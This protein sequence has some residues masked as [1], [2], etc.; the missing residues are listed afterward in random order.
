MG[1]QERIAYAATMSFKLFLY[2]SMTRQEGDPVAKEPPGD[3]Y[4]V[5]TLVMS[6]ELWQRLTLL[7]EKHD[8]DLSG[9][10]L[11]AFEEHLARH[12]VTMALP[13]SPKGDTPVSATSPSQV[14]EVA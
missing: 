1:D 3:L 7:S 13:G 4:D 6:K 12:E 8:K 5:G 10:M 11:M 9:E 2:P 14:L